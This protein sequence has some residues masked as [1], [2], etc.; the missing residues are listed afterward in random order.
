MAVRP[1]AFLGLALLWAAPAAAAACEPLAHEGARYT[2]CRVDL[3]REPL[4]L[5][6]RG[7]DGRPYGSFAALDRALAEQGKRL[8]LAMNAGMYHEDR[9]PVGLYV[10]DGRELA[11]ANT[12]KGPGNFHMLPNGV[13]WIDGTQAGVSETKRFVRSGRRVDYA[14]QSG[15]M[16]VIGGKLHP[17]FRAD[18]TSAKFRNGVC[19]PSPGEA[20][21]V[22]SEDRV[23]FHA[24]ATL[25][26]DALKCRDALYLDGTVSALHDA[27][28]GR[29]DR[30]LMGPILGVA[31]EGG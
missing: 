14:T 15:P 2:V 31:G 26:R 12:R 4:R 16:L 23:T 28:A 5:Y 30:S 20:A 21:L 24:F 18:G 27:A 22:I 19:A 10:E 3:E 13:F 8:L 9:S 6:L 1:L 29:S 17:R 11:P 25:F 7:E